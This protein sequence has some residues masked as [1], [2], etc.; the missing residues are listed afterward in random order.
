MD[1]FRLTDRRRDEYAAALADL[2]GRLP[3]EDFYAGLFADHAR[4]AREATTLREMRQL[5]RAVASCYGLR[6][7]GVETR[8][9]F[10][11]DGSLDREA[12]AWFG[13]SA[14]NVRQLSHLIW[15]LM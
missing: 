7:W 10:R 14:E 9:I 2:A 12:T 15:W 13:E 1:L 8:L 6:D 11:A 3:R 4:R 5:C